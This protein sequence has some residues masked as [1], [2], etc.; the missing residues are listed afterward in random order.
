MKRII[1]SVA[2]V[3]T[4]GLSSSLSYPARA[5]SGYGYLFEAQ[6]VRIPAAF[7]D[8]ARAHIFEAGEWKHH[9]Q[10]GEAQ[11]L[12]SGTTIGNL[13]HESLTHM[14]EKFPISYYEPR[15]QS[16][17]VQYIDVGFKIDA[18]IRELGQPSDLF[19]VDVRPERSAMVDQARTALP[20]TD[21]ITQQTMVLLKQ[22]QVAVMGSTSGRLTSQYLRRAYPHVTFSEHDSVALTASLRKF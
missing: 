1:Q 22:G 12:E 7:H 14:G 13:G 15:A 5:A 17:Q 2:L 4:L 11:I 10:A 9:L 3:L 20:E 18:K 6:V 16:Y 19:E 21:V 8:L